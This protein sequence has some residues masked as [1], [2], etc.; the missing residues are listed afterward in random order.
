VNV[1]PLTQSEE[2]RRDLML[3]YAEAMLPTSTTSAE[4]LQ[5]LYDHFVAKSEVDSK[6]TDAIGLA[7]GALIVR[8]SDFEWVWTD[9]DDYPPEIAV[10]LPA[11]K[12]VC[13]P[14][15]MIAKRLADREAWDLQALQ[16]DTVSLMRDKAANYVARRGH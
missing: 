10:G 12:L 6:V 11:L 7:F 14:I 9:G 15:S 1:R 4:S 2:G 3:E 16:R 8:S 5:Q 13:H